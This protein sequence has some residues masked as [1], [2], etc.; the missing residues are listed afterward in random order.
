VVCQD[1]ISVIETRRP[2]PIA[3]L[4]GLQNEKCVLVVNPELPPLIEIRGNVR[5]DLSAKEWCKPR[6]FRITTLMHARHVR[7]RAGHHG[8]PDRIHAGCAIDG[9]SNGDVPRIDDGLQMPRAT[10][11]QVGIYRVNDFTRIGDQRVSRRPSSKRQTLCVTFKKQ[12]AC[13]YHAV[14]G[15]QGFIAL[16]VVQVIDRTGAPA[17][18][19]SASSTA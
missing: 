9:V 15:Q 2:C 14:T 16:Q 1:D 17:N 4:G 19:R 12:H 8:E 5:A 6:D 10:G 13:T 7:G 3:H 11:T 18:R